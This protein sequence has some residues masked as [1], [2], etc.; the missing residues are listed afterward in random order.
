MIPMGIGISSCFF[1]PVLFSLVSAAA[2]PR[3]I[4]EYQSNIDIF[5]AI[6]CMYLVMFNAN[7]LLGI[8]VSHTVEPLPLVLVCKV[9]L[10][11]ESFF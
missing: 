4:L 3:C 7:Y 10:L 9:V 2:S 1:I 6:F 5:Y 11:I 8:P